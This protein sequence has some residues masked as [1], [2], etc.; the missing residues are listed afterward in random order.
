MKPYLLQSLHSNAPAIDNLFSSWTWSSLD[1]KGSGEAVFGVDTSEDD[2]EDDKGGIGDKGEFSWGVDT[3]LCGQV[4][5]GT[6]S[7]RGKD[8]TD[9]WTDDVLPTSE[10]IMSD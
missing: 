6:S 9:T 7:Q 1:N 5:R 8:L 3:T 2:E 4:T 10:I